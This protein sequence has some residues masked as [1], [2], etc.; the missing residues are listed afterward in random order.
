M[1]GQD[2]FVRR[3]RK[4]ATESL[5]S[6]IAAFVNQNIP[7]KKIHPLHI[8]ILIGPAG[9][10][11]Q[12]SNFENHNCSSI[13]NLELSPDNF[14]HIDSLLTEL[15]ELMNTDPIEPVW[16][17]ARFTFYHGGSFRFEYRFDYD[18]DWLMNLD[19]YSE[20]YGNL[21]TTME[22]QIMSWDGLS[23]GDNKLLLA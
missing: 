22:M 15:Y 12:C 10:T 6:T 14:R 5:V 9:S 19:P 11:I 23:L 16:N 13:V 20:T 7:D 3:L 21:S 2:T 17:K 8:D 1:K 4:E 18:L